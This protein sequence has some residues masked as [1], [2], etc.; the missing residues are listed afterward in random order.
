MNPD[1]VGVVGLW[2]LG[3]V[4]AAVWSK[5]G[6]TVQAVDFDEKTI[7]GLARGESP[8]FEPGITELIREGLSRQS[9]TFSTNP[10]RLK[11]CR[12]VFLT[13]D[14]PVAEDDASELKLLEETLEKIGPHLNPR[15]ILIVSAQLPVGTSSRFRERLKEMNQTLE[16]AYSPENLRLGEA[17]DCYLNPGHIVIGSEAPEVNQAVSDLFRPMK[18]EH[19]SMDLTSAE[20]TKHGINAFLATSIVF[21]NQFADLCLNV[22]ADLRKVV[23]AMKSDTRIGKRAYLSH[24]LGFSGG[25]LGRDLQALAK[26]DARSNRQSPF[27]GDVWRYNKNRIQKIGEIAKKYLGNL[28]G[29]TISLLGMTYK[30]GTS[31]L[32]RSLAI[33][34]ATDLIACGASIRAFDPKADWADTSLPGHFQ[35]FK[36]CYDAANDAELVVL[37]TEWPEFKQMDFQKLIKRMKGRFFFDV[38]DFL[39]DHHPQMESLGYQLLSLTKKNKKGKVPNG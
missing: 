4:V 15:S 37:L 2:H 5:I 1:Q 21:A 14:T 11:D 32:R 13:Y 19:F 26:A 28:Q 17:V 29:K 16:L 36:N 18:A 12:F 10:S 27:F 23:A 20:M 30:P 38:K 31:T 34:V 7:A 25:T 39:A 6:K 9:L 3:C 35:H 24:G 33:G 22:G 8:I